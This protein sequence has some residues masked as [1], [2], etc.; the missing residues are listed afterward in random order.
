MDFNING[1]L[2]DPHREA[3]K[4]V[5]QLYYPVLNKPNFSPRYIFKDLQSKRAAF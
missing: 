4:S 1:L 2:Q 3:C 5:I